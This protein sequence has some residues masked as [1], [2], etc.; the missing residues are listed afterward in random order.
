MASIVVFGV[1][2]TE[3]VELEESE[4]F[5]PI[6]PYPSLGIAVIVTSVP[7]SYSPAPVTTPPSPVTVTVYTG[8]SS[9]T[10]SRVV[11]SDSVLVID[12]SV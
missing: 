8:I 4:P 1:R 9:K 2:V 3:I 7:S 6:N 12:S 5:H 11:S 10:A